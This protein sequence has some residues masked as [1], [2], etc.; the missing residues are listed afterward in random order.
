MESCRQLVLLGC[1]AKEKVNKMN[2]Q[3]SRQKLIKKLEEI[4]HEYLYADCLRP[5][6]NCTR[7]DDCT[8]CVVERMREFINSQP[9]ADRWIPCGDPRKPNNRQRVMVTVDLFGKW[10]HIDT[11]TYYTEMPKGWWEY[12]WEGEGFYQS[13]ECGYCRREDVTAW[14]YVE[15]YKED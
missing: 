1:E 14:F 3:I 4:L 7:E 9:P 12:D 11:A 6:H 10:M 15:P 5:D 8:I 13:H 2:D